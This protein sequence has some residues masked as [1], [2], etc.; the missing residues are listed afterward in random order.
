M[1][2]VVIWLSQSWIFLLHFYR[3]GFAIAQPR[4]LMLFQV[5]CVFA[6]MVIGLMARSRFHETIALDAVKLTRSVSGGLGPVR[7]AYETRLIRDIRS[8]DVAVILSVDRPPRWWRRKLRKIALLP[9][10]DRA[11]LAYVARELRR[12][13]KLEPDYEA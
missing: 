9:E 3:S 7:R 13:L 2:V 1:F 5:C 11:E 10:R 12:A 6:G 8:N 4:G